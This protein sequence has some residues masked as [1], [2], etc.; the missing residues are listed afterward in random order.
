M[1]ICIPTIL[2]IIVMFMRR[3]CFFIFLTALLPT[4]LYDAVIGR[5]SILLRFVATTSISSVPA[6]APDL[7]AYLAALCTVLVLRALL[8]LLS[9][10]KLFSARVLTAFQLVRQVTRSF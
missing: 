10:R 8:R 3:R 5:C 2:V 7:S 6:V 1:I 9:L 4:S